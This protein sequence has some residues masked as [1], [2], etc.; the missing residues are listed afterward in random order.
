M[1]GLIPSPTVSEP[2]LDNSLPEPM[3]VDV[4]SGNKTIIVD[5]KTGFVTTF[6]DDGS[7]T[8]DTAPEKNDGPIETK[9]DE[10][11][12]EHID[13]SKLSEIS[14][15]LLEG[16]ESDIESRR[17]WV[18]IYNKAIDLL[19][20]KL[21]DAS[22]EVSGF[23][24]V[25]RV[26]HPLLLEAVVRS[27]ANARAELLPT[28]GPV[29]VRDDEPMGDQS[30]VELAEAMEKDFNHYLT[31][32]AKEYYP[33]TDKMFFSTFLCGNGFKKVYHCPLRRRPVSDSV[34]PVDLI[35]SNDAVDLTSAIRVT[36]RIYMNQSTMKRMQL[37]EQYLDHTLMQ[38]EEDSENI[39]E[40]HIKSIE[41]IQTGTKLPK[42]QRYTVYES[43]VELDLPGF[44]HKEKG[45][46]TGLP[47]PYR[48]TVDK[49]SREILEIRRNWKD[50]DKDFR[51]R[52]RFVKYPVIP[53]LGFYDYGYMHLL[54]NTTRALTAI[55]RQLLD[56]GQFNNFP[57]ML[58][59]KQ[60]QRQVTSQIRVPPGGAHEIDTG[61]QPIQDVV[62]PLP[63]K[64]A[65]ATLA[66]IAEKIAEDGRR[67]GS[68]TEIQAGEGRADVPVG[69]T[70]ALIEQATKVIGVV[71]K[72]LHAAQQEEFEI[73]KEL[74]CEDPQA[75]WRFAKNPARKWQQAEEF[76][77]FEFVP[78]SD[79]NI[80]SHIHRVMQATALIQMSQ[81]APQIYNLPS[82]HERALRTI[83]IQDADSLFAPPAPPGQQN[84]EMMIKLQELQLKAAEQQRTAQ[85]AV[86][87]IQARMKELQGN[88]QN[89]REN[90]ASKLELEK[91]KIQEQRLRDAMK[92]HNDNMT[93]HRESVM[94]AHNMGVEHGHNIRNNH[95]DRAHEVRLKAADHAMER[96][97]LKHASATNGTG[98]LGGG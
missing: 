39:N 58:I 85:Q 67:L 7:A 53:G 93:M 18:S 25:S 21:E 44:E 76:C 96:H 82:V 8:V 54:G 19:G 74:F 98:G 35:V 33:D 51:A 6:N 40:Q 30:R 81:A 70:I 20:L 84:P 32:I 1:A 10:N 83:G 90:R 42:D 50:G 3:E 37:S 29:K 65:S 4:S 28:N 49:D 94:E 56:A 91:L 22:S 38:P 13:H 64:G 17:E 5:P 16:I 86:L 41:G 48:I 77:D 71:H 34:S 73:F 97:K 45:K 80:P 26:Y 88:T 89:D 2:E 87:E 36:H 72:R 31:S 68:T 63:Y 46:A 78:A 95:A 55:E 79:P 27:Q 24:T 60:G 66:T 12:A 57:G 23:G 52:R 11:L 62:M 59:S 15:D 92:M 69:T 75:L 47:L 9:F 14:S 61:G 43:Y